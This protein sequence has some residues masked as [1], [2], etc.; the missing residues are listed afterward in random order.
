MGNQSILDVS[1]TDGLHSVKGKLT[2][3]IVPTHD[4]P[5]IDNLPA[6]HPIIEDLAVPTIIFDVGSILIQNSDG[7]YVRDIIS[8]TPSYFT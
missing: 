6:T 3:D 1:V 8:S 4:P 7:P 5:T 2:V